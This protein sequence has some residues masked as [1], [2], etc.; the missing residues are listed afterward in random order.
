M[1]WHL[2]SRHQET[3]SLILCFQVDVGDPGSHSSLSSLSNS[4]LLWLPLG[5]VVGVGVTL[6]VETD[7]TQDQDLVWKRRYLARLREKR[8]CTCKGVFPAARGCWS[9]VCFHSAERG[10]G[11]GRASPQLSRMGSS[12]WRGH[13]W[14]WAKGEAK[15]SEVTKYLQSHSQEV[16]V[17]SALIPA[18]HPMD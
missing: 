14:T 4:V 5:V 12:V 8:G 2:G 15:S 3:L 6:A 9:P 7:L 11:G 10:L 16:N 18:P 13:R 1:D 17:V